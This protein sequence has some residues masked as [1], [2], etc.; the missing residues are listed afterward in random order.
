MGFLLIFWLAVLVPGPDPRTAMTMLQGFGPGSIF[1]KQ[2]RF[3]V[4]R[5][6]EHVQNLDGVGDD[7]IEDQIVPIRAAAHT[8][9]FVSWNRRKGLRHGAEL[10]AARP[11]RGHEGFGSP[12]IVDLD[13]SS[14]P[15]LG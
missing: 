1:G 14:E 15:R 3:I 2:N 10:V 13:V 7:P 12:P 8:A 5:A 6:M 9:I 11:K 4:L